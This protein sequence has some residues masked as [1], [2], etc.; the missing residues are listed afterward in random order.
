MRDAQHETDALIDH[1]V[2]HKNV[3]P[4]LATRLIQ[5]FTSS[6]PSPR[7]VKA[8]ADAFKSG[9]HGG[10]TYGGSYGDFGAMFAAIVLDREARSATL[11]ADPTH[12]QLR[13]PL[14]KAFHAMR[15]L[16]FGNARRAELFQFGGAFGQHFMHS[17]TVFNFYD[18]R[19]KPMGPISEVG[20]VSPEAELG[21]G[22]FVVGWLNQMTNAVR[23]TQ[24]GG[25]MRYAARDARD[26]AA[27]VE[28]LELLLT[29]G[30]LTA[31]SRRM[32]TSAYN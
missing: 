2:W 14:L 12:G 15:A 23:A 24:W 30:R 1:L 4:F 19:Y 26:A 29:A 13:E 7:Y 10:R 9:A 32:L 20:L 25:R 3:A 27:V 22:P 6:N 17:P 16:D 31:A 8:V 11:D 28:E 5:R 21:T 18:P